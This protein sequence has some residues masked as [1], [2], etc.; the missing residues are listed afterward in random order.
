[1]HHRENIKQRV[2]ESRAK[3]VWTLPSGSCFDRR[4]I[5]VKREQKMAEFL[6][7][8]KDLITLSPPLSVTHLQ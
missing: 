3:R 5:I 8:F 1:M 2:S 6:G 4:S 7:H